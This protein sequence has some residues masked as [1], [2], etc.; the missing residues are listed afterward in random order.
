MS[1]LYRWTCGSL[2]EQIQIR[3]PLQTSDVR[4]SGLTRLV[5]S[6]TTGLVFLFPALT[7][8]FEPYDSAHIILM[9]RDWAVSLWL[10]NL[11]SRGVL[12]LVWA[13]IDYISASVGSFGP[14]VQLSGVPAL[15]RNGSWWYF[16]ERYVAL[17]V[18][19]KQINWDMLNGTTVVLV[20]T[21]CGIPFNVDFIFPNSSGCTVSLQ[22]AGWV[23]IR[24]S[25]VTASAFSP[26]METGTNLPLLN[27]T[28]CK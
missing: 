4:P 22:W 19:A 12:L 20:C 10:R 26:D 11:R 13:W 25:F 28:W 24:P 18:A 2:I 16:C 6:V 15:R 7:E 8:A 23:R 17:T 9:C 1:S 5:K 14:P 3:S 21:I 27:G